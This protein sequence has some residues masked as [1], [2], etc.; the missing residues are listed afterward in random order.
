MSSNDS[1]IHV[2]RDSEI[3]RVSFRTSILQGAALPQM[4]VD[5]KVA[6]GECDNP[7]VIFDFYGVEYF[8]ST[9]LGSLIS[10]QKQIKEHQGQLR[11]ASLAP[12]IQEL[13]MLSGLDKVFT[14]CATAEDAMQSFE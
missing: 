11:L 12:H 14:I 13:F 8:P 6:M 3:I 4:E 9:G 5:F 2:Y 10:M 1:P 7:R